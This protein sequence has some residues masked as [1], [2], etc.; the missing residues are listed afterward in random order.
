VALATAAPIL[1]GTP[2][3]LRPAAIAF[4]SVA[5][6]RR[7]GVALSPVLSGTTVAAGASL[8]A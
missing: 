4:P 2:L 1:T 5:L 6:R 7:I 3:L 8:I